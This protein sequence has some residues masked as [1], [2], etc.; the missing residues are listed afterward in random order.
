MIYFNTN[1]SEFKHNYIKISIDFFR[2]T[3]SRILF[4]VNIFKIFL[5]IM[6]LNYT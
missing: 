5:E 6:L 2:H 4:L 1:F 3:I